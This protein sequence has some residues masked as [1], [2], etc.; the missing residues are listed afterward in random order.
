MGRVEKFP[1]FYLCCIWKPLVLIK[2][3]GMVTWPSYEIT[4]IFMRLEHY[5]NI[6]LIQNGL[7][8]NW[9]TIMTLSGW[10]DLP[11]R[12]WLSYWDLV[13][14]WSLF[15]S[16]FS[17]WAFLS[18]VLF[19]AKVDSINFSLGECCLLVFVAAFSW[20]EFSTLPVLNPT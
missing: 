2:L 16:N 8:W 6:E 12:V 4:P 13:V 3:S 19:N 14:E 18:L 20:S 5:Q 7:L 10:E 17:I 15:P 9:R 1:F 11:T